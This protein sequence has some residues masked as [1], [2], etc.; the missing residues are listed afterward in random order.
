MVR[1]R[2]LMVKRKPRAKKEFEGQE[3]FQPS[4]E[5]VTKTVSRLKPSST[6]CE[7]CMKELHNIKNCTCV[8]HTAYKIGHND[9]PMGHREELNLV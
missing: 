7:A 4:K 6:M 5:Q 1:R 2:R 9:P 3:K 8:C